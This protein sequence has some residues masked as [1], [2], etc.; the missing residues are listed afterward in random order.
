MVLDITNKE[1]NATCA[2]ADFEF[3]ST[4]LI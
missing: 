3:S 2:L 1:Y 4:F